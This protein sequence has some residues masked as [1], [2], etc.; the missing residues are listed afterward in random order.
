MRAL[1]TGANGFLGSHLARRLAERGD[2][3]RC[4]VRGKAD[5][6]E[7]AKVELVQGDVTDPSSLLR[8]CQDVDVVFHIAGIRRA[9]ERET[10][11]RINAESTRHVCEAMLRTG[12]RRMVLAGSLAAM[13]P[14]GPERPKREDDPPDP[15]EAYGASKVEAE[16][17]AF[18]Y[19]DRLEITSVRPPRITGP[20]DRENL[21]FFKIV[22][23]G[24]LLKLSGGPRS[25][26]TVDVEDCVDL[27]ILAAEKKE[28]IGQAFFAP[29][30]ELTTL[31]G[32][33]QHAAD[34][35]GVKPR[36]LVIPATVL[37]GLAAGADWVSKVSGRHLPLNRKLARQLLAP[38][39]ACSG[40]K[41][42]RL[43]GYRPTRSLA[44]SIHRSA[45]WYQ[46]EGWL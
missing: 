19:A 25:L 21:A 28:A 46:R 12:A 38:G 6:L 41:A 39:W 20:G 16:R 9:P 44:D 4:L 3:V 36:T 30:P 8:A 34:A 2:Y 32:L 27:F 23:K 45:A 31:E 42:E 15:Q 18:G 7:G 14:A 37:L 10:F 35:L 33:Q 22:K 13:G 1:I 17:I 43:L 26:S 29:G 11:F 40:E 24:L 5:A